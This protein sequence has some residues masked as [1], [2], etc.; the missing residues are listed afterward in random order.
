ML[1]DF[2]S[3]GPPSGERARSPEVFPQILA[4]LRHLHQQQTT[5]LP[6]PFIFREADQARRAIQ[7]VRRAGRASVEILDDLAHK[8]SR[9][10]EALAETSVALTP[11]HNDFH[12][13]N[14]LNGGRVFVDWSSAGLGDP[15][16]DVARLACNLDIPIE[17]A[18][19]VLRAYQGSVRPEDERHLQLCMT[20][21]D[22][23]L[24]AWCA[25][26]P[27]REDDARYFLTRARH[28]LV[29]CARFL[30]DT[31]AKG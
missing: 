18:A 30:D 17:Q 27:G 5:D 25:A 15:Y 12:H 9:I 1:T 16:N 13:N 11:C 31:G 29:L 3:E 4:R 23:E 6:H 19:A 20:M 28:D 10:E 26:R 14:I 21:L 2:I 24:Y 7:A 22:I 8:V